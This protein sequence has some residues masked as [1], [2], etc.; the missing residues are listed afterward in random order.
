MNMFLKYF[1]SFLL[2]GNIYCII[3]L[4]YR[5]RT[6]YSMFFCSGL[7]LIILLYIYQGNKNIPPLLFG[8]TAS[9]VITSL[10]FVFG[11]VFNIMLKENVWDYSNTPLNIFG[12]ICLP[13]SIIWFFFGI[14]IYCL[15][16]NLSFFA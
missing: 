7:A 14:I 12:Q 1:F 13:F 10:E 6:H 15:F 2:G 9:A 11:V 16:K 4:L 3:E 5:S 8:L